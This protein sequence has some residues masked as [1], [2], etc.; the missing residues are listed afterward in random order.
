MDSFEARTAW[1]KLSAELRTEIDSLVVARR[2]IQ[3]IAAFRDRSG[4]E[5]RPGLAEAVELLQHRY[6]V[7]LGQ[8]G[9]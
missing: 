1:P 4:L 8:E 7:L 5:P 3:A 9:S 6:D 2:N